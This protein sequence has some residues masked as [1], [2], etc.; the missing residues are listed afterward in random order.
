MWHGRGCNNECVANQTGQVPADREF[1]ENMTPAIATG[2]NQ[3]LAHS[4]DDNARAG[5]WLEEFIKAQP[6]QFDGSAGKNVEDWILE[7][8]VA[9]EVN[10]VLDSRK[11]PLGM[12]QLRGRAEQWWKIYRPVDRHGKKFLKC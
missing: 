9:I 5:R 12:K 6:P 11:V 8:N 2:I 7:M 1:S 4:D 10:Q 3:R